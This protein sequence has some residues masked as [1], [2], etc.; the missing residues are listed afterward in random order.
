VKLRDEIKQ[1]RPFR[2]QAEE[3]FL[4]LQ[5][6]AQYLGWKWAARLK[7]WGLSPTQY[8]TLRILRGAGRKGLPCSEVGARMV[9]QDSDITRLLDRLEKR[10]LVIRSRDSKDRRVVTAKATS[11]GLELL[12]QLDGPA[13]QFVKQ[14]MRP[15]RPQRLKELNEDLERLRD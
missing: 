14:C 3:A 11:R 10:G 1:T 13:E 2:N 6:T 7:P 8:N 15:L 4:N 12:K 5:R 9:T